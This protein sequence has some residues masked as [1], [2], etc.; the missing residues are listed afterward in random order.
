MAIIKSWL[1]KARI[2]LKPA[3]LTIH[4][5]LAPILLLLT[6]TRRNLFLFTQN[7]ILTS[8]KSWRCGLVACQGTTRATARSSSSGSGG[9]E[10]R[11]GEQG[12]QTPAQSSSRQELYNVHGTLANIFLNCIESLNANGQLDMQGKPCNK[13]C[14]IYS[15]PLSCYRQIKFPI[16]EIFCISLKKFRHHKAK[17]P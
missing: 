10:G 11:V 3:R 13:K 7:L 15:D 5:W 16:K 12:G 8:Q 14:S 2:E 9:F 1:C 6:S 17:H 4:L